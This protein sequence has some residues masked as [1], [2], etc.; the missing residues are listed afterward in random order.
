MA[1]V[2]DTLKSNLLTLFNAMK[3]APMSDA[4]YAA[5]LTKII[6]D[7]VLGNS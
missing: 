2:E 4:D 5:Q 7:Q 3:A 1:L 6:S